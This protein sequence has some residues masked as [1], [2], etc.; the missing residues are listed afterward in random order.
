MKCLRQLCLVLAGFVTQAESAVIILND[1]QVW[2]TTTGVVWLSTALPAGDYPDNQYTQN[3]WYFTGDSSAPQPWGGE[4]DIFTMLYSLEPYGYRGRPFNPLFAQVLTA[5]G[6]QRGA[7]PNGEEHDY[8]LQLNFCGPPPDDDPQ[9]IGY[10]CGYVRLFYD[11][12]GSDNTWALTGEDSAST[13]EADYPSLEAFWSIQ[14]PVLFRLKAEPTPPATVLDYQVIVGSQFNDGAYVRGWVTLDADLTT[15]SYKHVDA[16]VETGVGG[17]VPGYSA[18][19]FLSDLGGAQY[20]PLTLSVESFLLQG[21]LNSDPNRT[22]L[23]HGTIGG[24]MSNSEPAPGEAPFSQEI[25]LYLFDE[26]LC[27]AGTG[28]DTQLPCAVTDQQGLGSRGYYGGASPSSPGHQESGL[29]AQL[30]LPAALED[31]LTSVTEGVATTLSVGA[32]D[33]GFTD[34]VTVTITMPPTKGTITAISAPGPV[35]GITI[36]YTA[37]AGVLGWDSFVY[38]MT[39]SNSASDS[40]KVLVNIQPDGDG[41][42]V[43]NVTDN[44]ATVWNATQCDSD[45]DSY[46]NHCDGD[47]TNNG[48]TN[49]QDT[50][51]FRNTLGAGTPGPTYNIG[52]LNCNGIV[53]AQD[54]VLFRRMLGKPPGPSGLIP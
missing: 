30:V 54:T 43:P 6:A 38:E 12:W 25:E 39:D 41:D 46:G 44:C 37:N 21:V 49:A 17:V 14:R 15:G 16:F 51:I 23:V 22:S 13:F 8:W 50:V 9:G 32:N 26:I 3:G 27:D 40:A 7:T 20:T 2:D 11:Q 47:M 28:P 29:W 31:G 35:A 36:T 19:S 4:P 53:N 1:H 42:G 18:P 52:D 34:P 33:L 10:E 5:L 45:G 48:F 24:F